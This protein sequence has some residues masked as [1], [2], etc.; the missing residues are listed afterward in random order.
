MRLGEGTKV[1]LLAPVIRAKK[2]EHIKILDGL[3]KAGFARARIDGEMRELEEEI[4]LAKTKRHTIEA[5]ID[6]IKLKSDSHGRLADSI[7]TALKLSGG[8]GVSRA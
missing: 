5:V 2:G 7:E 3:A 6:R 1:I 4:K 8:G